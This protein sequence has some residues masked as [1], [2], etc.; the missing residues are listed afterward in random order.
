[1]NE[2]F[3]NHYLERNAEVSNRETQYS[4]AS[5]SGFLSLRVT[6]SFS[7]KRSLTKLKFNGKNYSIGL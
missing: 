1:M 4:D 6:V 7:L 3:F 5:K 2:T